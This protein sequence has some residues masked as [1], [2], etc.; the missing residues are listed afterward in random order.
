MYL[1]YQYILF[2]FFLVFGIFNILL[3][4][5]KSWYLL[6]QIVVLPNWLISD[7]NIALSVY[8]IGNQKNRKLWVSINLY[9]FT[10]M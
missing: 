7:K 8:L 4:R 3:S 5:S 2:M 1:Y 9:N 6:L 10:T